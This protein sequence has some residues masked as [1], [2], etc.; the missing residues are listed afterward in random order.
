VRPLRVVTNDKDR[1][2]RDRLLERLVTT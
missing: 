1:V 2:A